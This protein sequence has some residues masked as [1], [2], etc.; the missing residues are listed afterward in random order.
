MHG[1]EID[2]R[3]APAALDSWS[4]DIEDSLWEGGRGGRPKR[5]GGVRG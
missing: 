5:G 3:K 2:S 4:P 1:I